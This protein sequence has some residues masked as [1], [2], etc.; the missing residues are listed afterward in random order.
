MRRLLTFVVLVLSSLPIGISVAGCSKGV[1]VTYCNGADTGPV[2]GQVATIDLEPRATGISLNQ[3][4]IGSVGTPTARDCMSNSATVSSYAYGSTNTNLVDVEPS[5]GRLCAGTWNRNTGGGIADFTVCNPN[6]ATGIAYITA[7]AA[8]ATSNALPVFVHPIVT[9]IVL[10]A[11]S[12]NCFTDPASNCIPPYPGTPLCS[13]ATATPPNSAVAYS[14]NSCVSQG[15]AAQLVARAYAGTATAQT[16]ISCLVGPLTFSASNPTSSSAATSVVTIDQNGVATAAEPGSALINA[17]ISQSSSTAG[18]FATCPPKSI[19]LTAAGSSTAPTAPLNI[20]QNVQQDLVATVT[21]TNGNPITNVTLSYQS[22]VPQTV[23]VGGSIVTPVFP[24]AASITATCQ[25]PTCNTAPFNQ[26]GLFGNGLPVTSN[27]V[28]INATGTGNSTVLYIGSTNSLYIQ[29]YD[30]TVTTQPAPTR[31]PYAP[32]SMVLSEDLSTIYM[33]NAN[34]IMV[35]STLSN[36]LTSQITAISGN[37][38][39]VSNDNSTIVVTDPVRQLVYLYLASGSIQSE[40]GGVGTHAQFS[41]DSQ[42]VYITTTDGRLLTHSNFTGWNS[43][44]LTTQGTDVAV[45]VPHAGAYLGG[46]PVRGYTICPATTVTG[47]NGDQT[48]TNVFYP[49]AD[50]TTAVADRIAAT[51]DGAHILGASAAAGTLTDIQVAAK[52]GACPVNFTSTTNTPLKFTAAIPSAITGILPTTDSTFALVTYTGAGGVVPQYTPSS[53]TLANIALVKSSSG[54]TPTA[55]VAG[56]I[57]SDNN[58]AY[59]GTSGDNL[60]HLLTRGITGFTDINT[61]L[62]PALPAVSSGIAVPNLIVQKPRKGT[63]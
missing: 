12:T 31:L 1:S 7:S 63:N 55:P 4:Q 33:G 2:V 28:Q 59:I 3:G 29:P 18:F 36:S 49:L 56:I 44:V 16:N 57:S 10:G 51:N 54:V 37:V 5:N 50:T 22:T 39:A 19:V 58:T 26:I 61:P 23:A 17:T 45:T 11:A 47:A 53:K 35:F 30:F 13:T 52:T 32:N 9:S 24:G 62:T 60:I 40:Y 27:N 43:E 25:P 38:L 20:T 48:T 15:Q 8:T 41:P 14:G 21:D 34:E 6:N 42:T 46:T